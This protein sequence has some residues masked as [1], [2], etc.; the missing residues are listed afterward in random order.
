LFEAAVRRLLEFRHD[1]L[2]MLLLRLQATH[3]LG[4]SLRLALGHAALDVGRREDADGY[5]A[6]IVGHTFSPV[7]V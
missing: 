2:L 7:V 3:F 4:R 6:A 1:R 5:R